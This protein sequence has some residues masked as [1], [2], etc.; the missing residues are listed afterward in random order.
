MNPTSDIWRVLVLKGLPLHRSGWPSKN[1]ICG[2]P[3]FK[4]IGGTVRAR[5]ADEL[6]DRILTGRLAPGSRL[7]L[8]QITREFG[9]SRTPVREAL[10]ELSYE[11]LVV[12]T[13]RSGITV[14]GITPQDAVDNFAVLA[15]LSGKAA[16]WAAERISDA[17]RAEL[18]R[19][20][21]AVVVAEDVVVANRRFHR[22][23]NAASG[24]RR[25][26]THLRQAV[27]VVPTNYFTLFPEQVHRSHADHAALVEAVDRGDGARARALAESHVLDAGAALGDWLR[28]TVA[29]AREPAS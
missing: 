25:L 17:G 7:D 14:L 18:R 3:D 15:T 10:L 24:S 22:A 19:L 9:T 28:T 23:L 2:M 29:G 11:G 27:R 1:V 12:V 6:R 13:P 20:A 5:A 8:D 4:P 21:D 26:L 16:E